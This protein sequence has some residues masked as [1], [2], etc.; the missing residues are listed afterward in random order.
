MELLKVLKKVAML[1]TVHLDQRV[2]L[3]DKKVVNGWMKGREERLDIA[4]DD[5]LWERIVVEAVRI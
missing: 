4:V 3:S 1:I 2:V 5:L